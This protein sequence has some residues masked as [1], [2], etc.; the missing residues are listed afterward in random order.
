MS[1]FELAAF[2][3]CTFSVGT[4]IFCERQ[5][6]RFEQPRTKAIFDDDSVDDHVDVVG[7]GFFQLGGGR[8]V[9][10][11]AVGAGPHESFAADFFKQ[12]AVPKLRRPCWSSAG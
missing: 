6:D 11:L 1:I 8:R 4:L 10:D 7:P 3:S 5:L 2:A 9:D 12:L